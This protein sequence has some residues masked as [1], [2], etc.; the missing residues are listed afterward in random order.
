MDSATVNRLKAQGV[1]PALIYKV[2]V[3]GFTA[4]EQSMGVV[5]EDGYGVSYTSADFPGQTVH[6]RVDHGTFGERDCALPIFEGGPT[7]S[8][9]CTGDGEGWY[10]K[11]GGRHEYVL[12]VAD[13]LLRLNAPDTALDHSALRASLT[14]A[15]PL[16]EAPATPTPTEPVPS[17]TRGDLPSIGDGAPLDPP[18]A[19]G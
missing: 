13:H 19:G 10:R 15:Q 5:G 8:I 9:V 16:I 18:P 7:A 14:N 6:L 4:A 3:P 11:G 1:D 12:P 2:D 17:V